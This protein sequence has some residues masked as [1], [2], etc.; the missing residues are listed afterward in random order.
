M[1]PPPPPPEATLGDD[2]RGDERTASS[3][4]A[5]ELRGAEIAYR[6][7]RDLSPGGFAFDDPFP[8]E[9]AGDTIVMELPLP[10]EPPIRVVGQVIYARP[11]LGVGVRIVEVDR[12][13]YA[14]LLALPPPPAP[15]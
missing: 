14:R 2:R 7:I 3:F 1:R 8:L 10:G 12:Q 4:Y 5:V 6:L 11:D 15:R 13:R 9:H